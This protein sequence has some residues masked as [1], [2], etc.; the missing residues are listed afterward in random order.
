MLKVQSA[1][2][3][4][5]MIQ[6]D[7][8]LRDQVIGPSREIVQAY[9]GRYHREG[10]GPNEPMPEND[11]F[12]WDRQMKPT[13]IMDNPG[14]EAELLVSGLPDML[15][16][17]MEA[18]IDVCIRESNF[19]KVAS[20]VYDDAKFTYG[21]FGLQFEPT[22]GHDGMMASDERILPHRPIARRIAPERWFCDSH[23]D[24]YDQSRRSGH[25]WMRDKDDLMEDPRFNR[26]V[27]AQ[28]TSETGA[29]KYKKGDKGYQHSMIGQIIGFECYFP[30]I[31]TS[32]DPRARG[33][34]YTL[35]VGQMDNN[36]KTEA[37]WIRDP[38]PWLGP[39]FGPYILVGFYFVPN[40]PYPI[41]PFAAMF[42]Q[43]K[44]TA[45]HEASAARS[46]AN[47]KRFIGVDPQYESEAETIESVQD[48]QVAIIKGL[49]DGAVKQMD[50][51]GVTPERDA[52]IARLEVKRQR[53]MGL[54]D[55]SRGQIDPEATATSVA[56]AANERD[57]ARSLLRGAF[58][59]A[60]GMVMSGF[61]HYLLNNQSAT[62]PLPPDVAER[63]VPRPS[64][65]PP[66]S[67]AELLAMQESLASGEDFE[68]ILTRV[69]LALQWRPRVIFAGGP[70]L[71][72][73][74]PDQPIIRLQQTDEDGTPLFN[75][76]GEPLWE[77][78][79]SPALRGISER[80][81]LLKVAP[82]SMER[83]DQ[84]LMQRRVKDAAE[85][86]G[87]TLD[88]AVRYPFFKAKA[89]LDMYGDSINHRN[90]GDRLVDWDL[91]ERFRQT[92]AGLIAPGGSGPGAGGGQF[93]APEPEGDKGASLRA[94]PEALPD[95]SLSQSA[96]QFGNQ[97]GQGAMA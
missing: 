66:E 52:Y 2:D 9:E 75:S 50:V 70:V 85:V 86:V 69:R 71:D 5:E 15:P 84:G 21:V 17:A 82:F 23:I 89:M 95:P 25:M 54:S 74:E 30:E 41:S 24:T 7:L 46:A 60:V 45:A 22:P 76:Q 79:V 73:S 36:D 33:S 14:C 10:H 68:S 13:I 64:T 65:L 67:D 80:D 88:L 47:A 56:D 93:P 32:D 63:F 19:A 18:G 27:L 49:K 20:Q 94:G 3:V 59:D 87:K 55:N 78:I 6:E 77:W 34:I 39:A 90:L 44:A 4:Y 51:G 8:K 16:M 53:M 26:E 58:R 57:V 97:A 31:R 42:E 91:F 43:V 28:I 81:W 40:C 37:Q 96:A 12:E 11:L 38:R 29:E 72:P 1:Q 61:A 92:Q 83:V 35:A 48:G 62:F